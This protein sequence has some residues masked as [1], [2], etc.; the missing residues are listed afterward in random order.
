MTKEE[1][2]KKEINRLNRIYK[3]LPKNQYT[4]LKK[5]IIEAAWLEVTLEELRETIDSYGIEEEYQNGQNQLG[6]KET[7]ASK[8][9]ANY[10][11]LYQAYIKI[12]NENIP[13]ETRTKG[14]LDTF[15]ND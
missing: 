8:T 12:L 4:V 5:I 11:K 13:P 3:V 14:K 15:L 9:F 6:I 2:A 7:V 1:K 10:T